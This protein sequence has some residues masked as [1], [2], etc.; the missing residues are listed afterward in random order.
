VYFFVDHEGSDE[1]NLVKTDQIALAVYWQAPDRTQQI[2]IGQRDEEQLPTNVNY[3]LD[4][5]T[6]VQDDFGDR[7]RMGDGDEVAAVAHPLAPAS[8]TV[9]DFRL[10]DSLTVRFAG[11]ADPI[12]V[13]EIRVRP[14]HPD[15]P[16]FI[17]SVYIDRSTA[18]VVRM[19]FTFTPASYVDPYLDFIRVSLDNALWDG[20]YWLPH[21]QQVEIRREAPYFDFPMGTVIRGRFEITG[22]ELNQPLPLGLF[23]GSRVTA[24]PEEARR[25]FDFERGLYDQI[26]EEG[27][28][29]APDLDQIRDQA[30]EIVRDHYLS[31]LGPIRPYAPG[32]SSVLRSNRAEGTVV[33]AGLSMNT[34][35]GLRVRWTGAYSFGREQVQSRLAIDGR[36]RWPSTLLAG[37]VNEPRDI[38][39]VQASSGAVNTLA[40]LVGSED[41]QDLYFSSGL[42]ASQQIPADGAWT[43]GVTARWERQRSGYLALD[44]ASSLRPVLS[45]EDGDLWSLEARPRWDPGTGLELGGTLALASFE[46]RAFT[47]L[48]AS[49]EWSMRWTERRADVAFQL[50][51]GLTTEDTPAQGLFLLGGRATL[52]G[53]PFRSFAGDRYWMARADGGIGAFWPWVGFRAFGAV[54]ATQMAGGPLPVEWNAIPSESVRTSVGLGLDLFWDVVRLELGRGLSDDGEWELNLFASTRFWP[55]L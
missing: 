11:P 40:V 14:R 5:L 7:I 9:Y 13:Y 22:Y 54:G 24:V 6:V 44:D 43:V 10:G 16:G 48:E 18:A 1:R 41:Y 15:R 29:P 25:A 36:N 4:H 30:A 12:R 34:G 52:P 55:I 37:F 20:T 32:V 26:E 23:R 42:I 19:R 39:P 50:R 2:I 49:G 3:H 51:G 21:R 28:G 27:L 31:G 35:L 38:G 46:G 33:G 8:E 47:R 53:Y 17:G 45:S